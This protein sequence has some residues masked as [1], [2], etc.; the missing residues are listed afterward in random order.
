MA[1]RVVSSAALPIDVRP[2]L[3]GA[4]LVAPAVGSLDRPAL[5]RALAEADGLI[6]QL[7]VRVDAELLAAAP[8]LRIAANVSWP[9]STL[10]ASSRRST[11]TPS[12]VS[13]RFSQLKSRFARIGSCQKEIASAVIARTIGGM[14]N[15]NR[16]P[17]M[18]SISPVTVASKMGD[19]TTFLLT[20]PI[21]APVGESVRRRDTPTTPTNQMKAVRI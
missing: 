6:S 20:L 18:R 16:T 1:T 21:K 2:L 11:T 19:G 12:F 5:L 3:P 10:D 8:R 17:A 7:D 13:S 4:D 15:F 9:R 14:M